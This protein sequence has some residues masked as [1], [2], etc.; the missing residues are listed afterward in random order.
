M[1][2]FLSIAAL[3]IFSTAATADI[4]VFGSVEQ[5]YQ[6]TGDVADVVSGDTNIGFKSIEIIDAATKAYAQI[7]LN[8]DSEGNNATTTDEAYVGLT[9]NSLDIRGGKMP[10]IRKI[11]SDATIDV[12]EGSSIAM[13]NSGSLANT[14]QINLDLGSVQ[15]AGG[16]T[17]DG[18]NRQQTR[19]GYELAANANLDNVNVYAVLTKDE[20]NNIES[21]IVAGTLNTELVTVGGSFEAVDTAGVEVDTWNAVASVDVNNNTLI[22]GMQ[23]I[24]NG[25][26]TKTIEIVHNFTPKTRAYINMQDVS[27]SSD[28]VWQT[29]VRMNF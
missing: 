29:G 11:A 2:K 21:K 22:V 1:N 10:N 12:F 3:A 20:V 7:K 4:T 14:V 17:A 24:E 6:K 26:D 25:A 23:D 28:D 8:V 15:L 13:Q 9:L 27:T 19:D 16:L 18:V 5:A